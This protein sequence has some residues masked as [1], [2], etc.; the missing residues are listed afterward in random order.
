MKNFSDVELVE[1]ADWAEKLERESLDPDLKKSYGA[2]RQGA[3]WLL[4]Y[5]TKQRQRDLENSDH[6]K[7]N[8]TVRQM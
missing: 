1:L 8:V 3:D 7:E 6:T 5:R 2:I 4:R